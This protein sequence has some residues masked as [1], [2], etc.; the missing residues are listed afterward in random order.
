MTGL[1]DP[2][3]VD[4][5]RRQELTYGEVGRTRQELPT[6]YAHLSRQA[7]IG[8]GQQQFDGASSA[9]FTWQLQQR[10]GVRVLASAPDVAVGA[11][12]VLLLGVGPLALRAPV[13]VV[14]LIDEP[15]RKGFA[16]GTLPGHPERGE[17]AF[18][19]ELAPDE[20][21]HCRI[22]AFSRPATWL[23]KL[24]GPLAVLT[25][26]WVTARYLRALRDRGVGHR[27]S[28]HQ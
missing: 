25:Q 13:R 10:A 28:G 3:S 20:T 21:V 22:T 1:L 26:R 14:Y 19:V 8:Q 6:G 15:R 17:E 5:L 7:R 11:V 2:K 23:A 9:L 16:Y 4:R 24:S 18:V 27:P 12:A